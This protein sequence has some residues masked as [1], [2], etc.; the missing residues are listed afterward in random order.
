MPQ[1][2]AFKQHGNNY[3]FDANTN[4]ILPLSDQQWQLAY[5]IENNITTPETTEF[6][7]SFQQKG[8][9]HTPNITEIKHPETDNLKYY[10]EKKIQKL[11]LQITQD[12]NLRCKY[13]VYG[14]MYESRPHTKNIMSFETAKK[15]IDY[16]FNHSTETKALNFGFY[17]GEPL[18][19]IDFVKKCIDYINAAAAKHDKTVTFSITT[20]GTLLTVDIY[21]VFAKNKVDM[22]ISIDGTKTSHD[23]SR[24]FP[25]G[26]GS[27]DIIMEN[28]LA[29]QAKYPDAKDN[30]RFMAVANPNIS[31]AC[32]QKFYS[33]DEI[34]PKNNVSM[35]FISE[36]YSND[37]V[38]LSPKLIETH[39]QEYAKLLLNMLGK[40][41]DNKVS[42]IL[43]NNVAMIHRNYELLYRIKNLPQAM[44]PGGPCLAGV[45]RLFVNTQ[46]VFYPCERVSELSDIMKIGN[47]DDGINVDKANAINN[48]GQTT[49][50]ACKKCW[51]IMHCDM[52][53]A[54]SDNMTCLSKSKRL[55]N[56]ER[57]KMRVEESF[58][59]ICFLKSSGY[60][61]EAKTGEY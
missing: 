20:N 57:T 30:L 58:K 18:L 41:D 22:L 43:K 35:T 23:S 59:D 1:I 38:Y 26:S 44:H 37:P 19:E 34:L 7:E 53:A 33:I 17:G 31:D 48:V 39:T 28:I 14:G 51:A 42:P 61:F 24:V 25:D 16:V 56:C 27:F 40:I 13:C 11:T 50:D 6:L 55:N 15:A 10:L 5:N 12:C 54:I 49:A 46:G 2:H 36:L 4:T 29:I 47:V 52:C 32:V 45:H 21:E 8:F 3:V 60:D 9:F